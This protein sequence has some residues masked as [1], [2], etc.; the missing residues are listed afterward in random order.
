MMDLSDD[1]DVVDA[2][3]SESEGT[4]IDELVEDDGIVNIKQTGETPAMEDKTGEAD[5]E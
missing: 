2:G 5:S 3:T 1:E 4:V